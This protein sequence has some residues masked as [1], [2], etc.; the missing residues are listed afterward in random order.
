MALLPPTQNESDLG[1]LP[2]LYQCHFAKH[3]LDEGSI[4]N[5]F[6]D[7]LLFTLTIVNM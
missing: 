6:L 7:S 4:L 1:R 3:C 5:K 2:F